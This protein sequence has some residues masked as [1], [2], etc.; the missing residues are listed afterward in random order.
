M[1]ACRHD[2]VMVS[3]VDAEEEGGWQIYVKK[4]AWV[5]HTIGYLV[6]KP[7]FKHDFVVLANSHLPDTGCWSGLNRI[8]RGMIMS[9]TTLLKKIPCGGEISENSGNTGYASKTRSSD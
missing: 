6:E 1:K 5:I 4:P 9:I 2:L 7:K 8:P 3:W